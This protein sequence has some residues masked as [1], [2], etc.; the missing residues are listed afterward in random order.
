MAALDLPFDTLL[1]ATLY[2]ALSVTYLVVLPAGLYY[3][4][5][6]RSLVASSIERLFMYFLVFFLFPGMLLLSPFLNLRPR[7]RE[8]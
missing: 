4:V 7:R 3:Y 5:N 2:L 6:K 8:V 1:L